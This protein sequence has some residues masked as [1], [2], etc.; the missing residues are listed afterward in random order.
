MDQKNGR[1]AIVE[2]EIQQRRQISLSKSL[3]DYAKKIGHGNRSAGIRNA[4]VKHKGEG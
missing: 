1:P 4:L 2:G 3:D